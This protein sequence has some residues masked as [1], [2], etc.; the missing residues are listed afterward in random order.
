M[1]EF[2]VKVELI[3]KTCNQKFYSTIPDEIH[4]QPIP[5]VKSITITIE[6]L[7]D[8]VSIDIKDPAGN[9]IASMNLKGFTFDIKH[10]R[11]NGTNKYSVTDCTFLPS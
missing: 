10:P 9:I 1:P 2:K 3:C 11:C 5:N 6:E 8:E 4:I 7:R